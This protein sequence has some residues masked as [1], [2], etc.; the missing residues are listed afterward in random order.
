MACD[1]VR[2]V[3]IE[4]HSGYR[5]WVEFD[6]GTEGEL[7]LSG[8]AGRGVFSVWNEPGVFESAEITPR[9]TIR[10]TDDAELCADAVYLQI[11]GLEAEQLMPG[12]RTPVDA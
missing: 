6:D 10:W 7:D 8:R 11:T 9:R 4:A 2:P 1:Q 12:L 3:S 5:L